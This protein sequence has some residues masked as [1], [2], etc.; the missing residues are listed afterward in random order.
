[1]F[2]W[3]CPKCGKVFGPSVQECVYC[4]NPVTVNEKQPAPLIFPNWPC[5]PRYSAKQT[6]PG[7]IKP[8]GE[9][10]YLSEDRN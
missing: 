8:F 10:V 6:P 9:D 5:V 4:N 7:S 3:T 2:G 1:M